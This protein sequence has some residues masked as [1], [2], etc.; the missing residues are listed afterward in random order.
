M[1]EDAK[2][3]QLE[4]NQVEHFLDDSLESPRLFIKSGQLEPMHLSQK[5]RDILVKGMEE[6][7]IKCEQEI[8]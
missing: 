6:M 4:W 7:M 2:E 1:R 5:E 3:M 8:D